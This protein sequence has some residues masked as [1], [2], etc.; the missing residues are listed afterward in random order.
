MPRY[1]AERAMA[2]VGESLTKP[3]VLVIGVAYKPGVADVRETPAL[4]LINHL[5]DL[6]A[7]VAWHDPLVAM[8]RNTNSVSLDW[9]CDVAILTTNQKG[10]DIQELISRNVKVLDCSN[11]LERQIG[12]TTL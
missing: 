2:I 5:E 7:E 3:K 9:K 10:L 8:W 6:G 4:E 1:V 11:S 12:V